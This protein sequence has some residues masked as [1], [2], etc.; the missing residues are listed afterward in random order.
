LPA[1]ENAFQKH[2]GNVPLAAGY[3]K[4]MAYGENL[5][6]K[7]DIE[8]SGEKK[9]HLS[10]DARLIDLILARSP[11]MVGFS[12]Y[13]WNSRRGSF[14]AREVKKRLPRIRITVGGPE[15]SSSEILRFDILKIQSSERGKLEGIL[16]S[17]HP[18]RINPSCRW[19]GI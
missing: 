6:D 4:A 1:P 12:L 17:K 2:G 9:T 8:I 10:G 18:G 7:I 15:Q 13:L 19:I 16:F 11:D 3:L 14:I 5:L